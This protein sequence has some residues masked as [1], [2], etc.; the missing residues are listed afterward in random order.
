MKLKLLMAGVVAALST[1]GAASAATELVVNGGFKGDT[2]TGFT[3][4][5]AVTPA[6]IAGWTVLTNYVDWSNG[7]WQSSDGDGYSL[8]LIGGFGRGAIA[9]TIATQAGRTYNLTFD[10]SGNPDMYRDAGRLITVSAGGA[11]IGEAQYVLS[12]A[13]TRNNMVW[14]SRS[15]SFVA[16][17]AFTQI[18]FTGTSDNPANCCWGAALDNVSVMAAVPEPATWAMM[19]IGFGVA[20]SMVRTARRRDALSLA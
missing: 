1:A 14:S 2:R 12:S 8:D 3:T 11:E 6:Q 13:N 18:V 7:A 5:S 9:Q 20:G 15:M 19:I 17:G 16:T 4:V 10:I